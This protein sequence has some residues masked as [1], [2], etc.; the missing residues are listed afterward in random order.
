MA[1]RNNLTPRAA[2]PSDL[3]VKV[4]AARETRGWTKAELA[5]KVGI[6]V[7]TVERLEGG[8]GVSADKILRIEQALGLGRGTLVPGWDCRAT[9]LSNATGARIREL[10][11]SFDHTLQELAELLQTSAS[12]LSR[13]ETG[14]LGDIDNWEPRIVYGLANLYFMSR[15]HFDD[16]V[17]GIG[18]TPQP[19]RR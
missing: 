15:C 11:R 18:P 17:D 1:H 7:R 19:Y 14:L 12:T 9:V 8:R 13:L 3:H 5:T 6:S 4:T 16:W 2:R 10:R